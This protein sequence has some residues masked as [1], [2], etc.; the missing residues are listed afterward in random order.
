MTKPLKWRSQLCPCGFCPPGTRLEW[1]HNGF[2][3][4]ATMDVHF[5]PA[6][7][8][9]TRDDDVKAYGHTMEGK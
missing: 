3:L 1:R 2:D 6:P 8:T 9:R 4:L 7:R 5:K